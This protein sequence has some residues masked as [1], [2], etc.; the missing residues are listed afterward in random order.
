MR[1]LGFLMILGAFAFPMFFDM[2]VGMSAAGAASTMLQSSPQ[3]QTYS[4]EEAKDLMWRISVR[5]E[6]VP[7]QETYT[8]EQ[9]QFAMTTTIARGARSGWRVVPVIALVLAALVLDLA[10]RAS[11]RSKVV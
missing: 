8:R 9:I 11:R 1:L 10:S 5:Q 3:Q 6:L 2:M 7:D 4:R